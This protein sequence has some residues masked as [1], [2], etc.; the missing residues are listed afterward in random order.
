MIIKKIKFKLKWLIT[1]IIS[2]SIIISL[3]QMATFAESLG[4]I[5]LDPATYQ[6]YLK[7]YTDDQRVAAPPSYD[8]RDDGIVTVAKDQGDCGSCWAFASVG[9]MESHLMKKWGYGLSDLS[10]Q[11]QVSCNTEMGGCIG[12]SSSA[13]KWWDEA[14]DNGPIGESC[15][16]YTA[17]N[18]LFLFLHRIGYSC[19]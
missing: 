17:S 2:V 1:V 4:D 14:H 7:I 19:Y 6:K 9:A 8:A 15:F 16:P 18:T 12:G 13:I 3:G 10:E 5:P 11:K